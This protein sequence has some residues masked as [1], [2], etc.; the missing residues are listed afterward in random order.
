MIAQQ[1]VSSFSPHELMRPYAFY[2]GIS[3]HYVSAISATCRFTN[4]GLWAKSPFLLIQG[5]FTCSWYTP[6]IVLPLSTG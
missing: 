5:K 3:G 1:E 6:S 2:E 4:V